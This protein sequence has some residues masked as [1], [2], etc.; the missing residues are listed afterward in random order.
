M[1]REVEYFL[2]WK[3]FLP[4]GIHMNDNLRYN[5]KQKRLS[6]LITKEAASMKLT[7]IILVCVTYLVS[8]FAAGYDEKAGSPKK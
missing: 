7:I 3:H 2:N 4:A 6:V 1:A 8:I 5:N